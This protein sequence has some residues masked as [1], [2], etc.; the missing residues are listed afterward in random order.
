MKPATAEHVADQEAALL[1]LMAKV[2]PVKD[3]EASLQQQACGR[4][5]LLQPV[6]PEGKAAKLLASERQL[7]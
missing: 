2:V 3:D 5:A 1:Y 6:T 7:A 4:V